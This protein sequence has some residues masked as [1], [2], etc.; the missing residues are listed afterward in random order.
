VKEDTKEYIQ[1]LYKKYGEIKIICDGSSFLPIDSLIKFQGDLKKLSEKNIKRLAKS[2]F[3]H[4]FAAPFFIFDNNGDWCLLDGTQRREVINLIREAGIPIPGQFPVI[5]IQAGSEKKAREIL[6]NIT[7]SYGEFQKSVLDDWVADLD[8]E[9][10]ESLRITD[11]E[12]E[13]AIAS[14]AEKETD[15]DDDVPEDVTPITELGDLW[16]LNGH[17]LLCGDSTKVE[18]VEKLMNGQKADMVFTDPPYSVEYQSNMRTKSEKFEVLKNDD[19]ILDIYPIINRFSKGWIFIWTS[20]KV[21]NQWIEK[22]SQ[23]KYPT[24]MVIWHKPGGGIG[25]LKKTFS[26]DYEVA[27]VWH[28]GKTR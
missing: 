18:D 13:L 23:L 28:R 25:D 15:G 3:Y 10:A 24:N 9:I 12:M 2:I 4:G 26:S 6:L 27:L 11:T 16:E 20:W 1:E 14:L 19:T 7:S 22:L 8:E 17:Q 21:Q 5:E